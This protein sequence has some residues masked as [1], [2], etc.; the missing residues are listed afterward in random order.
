MHKV[1]WSDLTFLWS[2]SHFERT[3]AITT[4]ELFIRIH[5]RAKIRDLFEEIVKFATNTSIR[6]RN[7]MWIIVWH[8]KDYLTRVTV[9]VRSWREPLER[10]ENENGVHFISQTEWWNWWLNMTFINGYMFSCALYLPEFSW[11][12]EKYKISSNNSLFI[13]KYFDN[14][15]SFQPKSTKPAEK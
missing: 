1:Y 7:Q 9:K 11:T 12:Q 14:M 13:C 3:C 10:G 2:S 6:V 8:A 15:Q 4:T 5:W